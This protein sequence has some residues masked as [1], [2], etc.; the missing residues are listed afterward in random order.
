MLEPGESSLASLAVSQT[1]WTA[2]LVRSPARS[3]LTTTSHSR[4]L[5]HRIQQV[6][7]AWGLLHVLHSCIHERV[8]PRHMTPCRQQ[9]RWKLPV[10]DLCTAVCTEDQS[11]SSF[12]PAASSRT[13]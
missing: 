2:L 6:Q 1:V 12:E 11:A 7:H 9:Q 4:P 10:C 5:E 8:S 13:L 3:G